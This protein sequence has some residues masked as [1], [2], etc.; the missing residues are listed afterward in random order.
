MFDST[1]RAIRQLPWW[2]RWFF[3]WP[4]YYAVFIPCYIVGWV[5]LELFSGGKSW[6][7]KTLAPLKFPIA[8]IIALAA[9]YV[10]LG[11]H[12]FAV[13][14]EFVIVIG[15]IGYAINFVARQFFPKKKGH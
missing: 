15:C 13:T 11:P 5:T 9:V 4:A 12:A 8:A 10:L 3:A 1:K 14:L 2:G 6:L 7:G